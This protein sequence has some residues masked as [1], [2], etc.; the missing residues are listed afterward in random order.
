M[1]ELSIII[2]YV[3]EHPQIAFTV[4]SLYCEL[5]DLIDFEIIVVDNFCEEVAGQLEKKNIAPDGGSTYMESLASKGRPWLKYFKYDKKLS[6]WNAKNLGV[7]NATGKFLFFVDSHC[8]CSRGSLLAMLNWYRDNHLNCNGTVHLPLSYLLEKPGGELIYKLVTDLERSVVHY[9]F[10]RYRHE[11]L[12][13]KVPCMS[14][15]GMMMTREIYDL[16]GGWPEE[17]GIYGGGENFINYELA[18]L[19]K[20]KWIYPT[21]PLFHYAAPR[22]YYWNYNDFH[23]NRTIASYMY[24]GAD[25]AHNYITHVKGRPEVLQSIYE[26]VIAKTKHH[27]EYLAPLHKITIEDWVRSQGGQ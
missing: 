12:P 21:Y 14:T 10:T 5:R 22:G 16:L 23:R 15:C 2:P 26:D 11:E 19:G 25:F 6:H 8:I 24:G 27:R 3:Q 4:Q 17:M 13:Y 7:K 1:A 20:E 18:V 9:S